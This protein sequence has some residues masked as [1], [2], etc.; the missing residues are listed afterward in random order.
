MTYLQILVA[1]LRLF[2]GEPDGALDTA[3]NALE[4]A[5]TNHFLLEQ[6]AGYRVLGQ[7]YEAMENRKEADVAFRRSLHVLEGIQSR[8]ELAQTLLAYGRFKAGGD[9]PAEGRTLIERALS[10]FEDMGATGWIDEAR[11]AL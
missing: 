4:L 1:Y 7:V 8:P 5:E 10:L 6:G 2:L 9:D 3:R 11:A